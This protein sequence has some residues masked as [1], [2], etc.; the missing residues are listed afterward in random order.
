HEGGRELRRGSKIAI[1]ERLAIKHEGIRELAHKGP[2]KDPD[3][4]RCTHIKD[5]PDDRHALQASRNGRMRIH[6]PANN[7][8]INP[9]CPNQT[10]DPRHFRSKP[11]CVAHMETGIEPCPEPVERDLLDRYT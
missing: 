2:E 8:E 11:D 1:K 7:H 6:Q 9:P 10:P 5:L 4:A 3:R